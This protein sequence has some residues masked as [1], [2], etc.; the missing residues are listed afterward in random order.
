M[1]KITED[2]IQSGLNQLIGIKFLEKKDEKYKFHP[3]YKK[4]L[5][6]SKGKSVG[7]VLLDSLWRAGYFATP[8]TEREIYVVIDLLT[9]KSK[10]GSR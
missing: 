7:E 5:L 4:T 8:R 9:L 10:N 2:E 3:N 6:Q 1:K